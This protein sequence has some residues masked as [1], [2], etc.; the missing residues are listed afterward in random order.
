L[1]NFWSN[2][3][4][5]D[6]KANQI[7]QEF[8]YNNIGF[9]CL[10]NN[11]SGQTNQNTIGDYCS[12]N[13][14]YGSFSHNTIGVNFFSNEIQ[15]GFG[16]GGGQYK[17]NI[18]GNNFYDNNIGEYFYDNFIRDNF[19]NNTV[20]DYFQQN[21]VTNDVASI[22]FTTATTV[23]GYYNCQIFRRSDQALR[24]SYYDENDV[25]VITDITN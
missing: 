16:F 10:S 25:L 1:T 24:L 4:K 7:Y 11:F 8:G 15:D 3:L 13:N 9:G 6:F 23:Y 12:F 21:T 19:T 17:G 20:V 18:I 2:R 5:T 14:L 22:D